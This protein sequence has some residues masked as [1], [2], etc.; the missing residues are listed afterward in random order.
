MEETVENL[1]TG[2]CHRNNTAAYAAFQRLKSLS[3]ESG[4]VAPYLGR[5]I[6]LTRSE[7]SYER[8]R[9]LLLIS[10][11]VKWD[12]QGVL[13]GFL[14]EYLTHMTDASPIAARQLIKALP[15]VA[16]DRPSWREPI[17]QAA[18]R[19]ELGRYPESMRGL[20]QKDLEEL[21]RKLDR[22]SVPH[23]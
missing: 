19:A 14:E 5:L 11:N 12:I 10:S 6:E 17:R 22:L 2:L 20:L 8:T 1:I 21:L 13:D 18:L 9:G 15:Q 7:N 23:R 4:E 3:A 16:K